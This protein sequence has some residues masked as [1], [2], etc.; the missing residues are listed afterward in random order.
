MKV[1]LLTRYGRLGVTSR[2]RF[3][4]YAPYLEKHGIEI[5]VAPFLGDD[6]V[7][8]L[9][10]GQ[11]NV[12]AIA[13][14]YMRRFRQLLGARDYD[15]L[16]VEKEFLPWLPAIPERI[17]GPY[18]VDYDDAVFHG[19]DLNP[20][21]LVRLLL[22]NKIRVTMSH[23]SV[24]VAGNEYLASYAREAGASDIQNVP[25][26]VDLDR[27]G[28][29][30]EHSNAGFTIGWIGTPWTARY[31]PEIAPAL[32]EACR[33]G[34]ARLL[35]IGSGEIKL[36]DIPFEVCSWSESSE[37]ENLQRIDVGIMPLPD[38]PY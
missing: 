10:K 29:P 38:E 14:A 32:H 12:M 8:S 11:R 34:K 35:L 13:G 31:L 5:T 7:Q 15:L 37:I 20:S 2:I 36:P 18:V 1:L 33:N 24:V 26:V 17:I 30:R 6:Y 16:W 3:L 28:V 23:A 27:Y 22:G 4:Q 21:Y 19:Y 9:Y 25:T